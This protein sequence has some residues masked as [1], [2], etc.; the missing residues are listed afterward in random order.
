MNIIA[1]MPATKAYEILI[2]TKG[3]GDPQ[4]KCCIWQ[5]DGSHNFITYIPPNIKHEPYYCY[6][7]SD[8]IVSLKNAGVDV[9]NGI[10]T[11][12]TLDY[13]TTYWVDADVDPGDSGDYIANNKG[14]YNS[15]ACFSISAWPSGISIEELSLED[16]KKTRNQ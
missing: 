4:S 16:C 3:P 1:L 2:K 9:R 12:H 10:A 13:T 6:Y 5:E 11:F 7:C 15:D 14:G 8:D